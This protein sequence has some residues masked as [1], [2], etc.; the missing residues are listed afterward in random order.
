MA[1]IAILLRNATQAVALMLALL[2]ASMALSV[3][4]A[5]AAEPLKSTD[6]FSVVD[7]PMEVSADNPSAARDRAI[8]EA[9]SLA[10]KQL[11]ERLTLPAD[12]RRL[13]RPDARRLNQPG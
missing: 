6:L 11:L 12:Q 7:L 4:V 13:P 1:T 5:I 2:L 8:E 3:A 9:Q 10:L